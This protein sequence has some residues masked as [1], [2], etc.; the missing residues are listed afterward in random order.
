MI[1]PGTRL[2]PYEILSPL[3]AGGMGEVYRARDTRLARDVAVK[4]LPQHLSAEPEVRARFEREARTVSSLNHPHICTLFDVGRENETDYL[5]MELVEG[6]TLAARLG[7]GALPLPEVYR[8]GAQIADALDRAHRAG[9]I[10]RDL[11]PANVMVTKAGAKLM[12]FGLAR[13]TGLATPGGSGA[14]ITGLTQSPTIAS[15]LTAEGTLVGTFQYMSPEQLEGREADARSDIWA[16]GCVLYEMAT[17]RRAFEGRSQASLIASILAA[18]PPALAAAAPLAP[19]T[20]ENLVRSC[21]AKDP[22]ERLQTAHDVKLQL[23]WV[24]GSTSSGSTS[25]AGAPVPVRRGRGR[26][27][28]TVAIAALALA[29][30]AAAGWWAQ[31]SR[32]AGRV[33]RFEIGVAST[34]RLSGPLRMSPDGTKIAFAM[35]DT[36]GVARV[37]L[38]SFDEIEP[39]PMAGTEGAGRPFWSPDSRWIAFFSGGK[40]RKVPTSGGPAEVICDAPQGSDGTW[41]RSG[42]ILYDGSAAH[43]VID[44][45]P[46]GGGDA[47]TIVAPDTAKGEASTNWPEAM[48][49]GE[50]FT[51]EV[52]NLKPDL[53]EIRMGSVKGGKAATIM[54]GSGRVEYKSGGCLLYVTDRS[55]VARPMDARSGRF[56]GDP[57]T[58]VD[59]VVPN[60]NNSMPYFSSSENGVLVYSRGG[61][62]DLRQ[63]TW[64]DRSGRELERVMPPAAIKSMALSPDG[65][66][67]AYEQR[68]AGGRA[69]DLWVYEFAR[70]VSSRFTMDPGDDSWPVWARDGRTLYWSTNPDGGYSVYSRAIDAVSGDALVRKGADLGPSDVSPDGAW[71]VCMDGPNPSWTTTIVSL[72]G[73]G[74]VDTLRDGGK[75]ILRARLSPDGR[76]LAYESDRSGQAEIYVCPFPALA[77]ATQVSSS[78]GR[79]PLWRRDGQELYF[80]T[81]TGTVFAVPVKTGDRFE[82]GT[83]RFLFTADFV[84]PG[85]TAVGRIAVAADG[86]RFLVNVPAQSSGPKYPVLLRNWPR[87]AR[88]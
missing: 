25:Q 14:S 26:A 54:R 48:T 38:R 68:Q 70:G 17:G 79:D 50:H 4:V 30:G 12:D 10:H 37:Y 19:P 75:A 33:E 55:L 59:D 28:V 71:L 77:P 11:K 87:L 53:S 72:R 64:V 43:P 66:R 76:W 41:L 2:G 29:A 83:P 23:G 65:S 27:L 46:A 7:R 52:V 35:S 80:R 42:W 15:P 60:A 21:L 67:L 5:V 18:E 82:S 32:D 49:D 85:T 34:Q 58:I 61:S 22:E 40:L 84:P 36:A 51:Y 3:G 78:G 6:E 63:L 47:R 16:L 13:A 86:Q 24:A 20:L 81:S 88:R 56:T 1:A 39:R 8:L 74:R 62:S 45:V 57:H 73:D 31:A 69:S 44:C 9:V